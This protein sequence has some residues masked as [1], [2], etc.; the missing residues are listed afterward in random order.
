[1][2]EKKEILFLL[3]ILLLIIIFL[4]YN[5]IFSIYEITYDVSSKEMYADNQSTVKISVNSINGLGFKTPFRKSKTLFTIIEG[6]DLVEIIKNDY[7]NGILIVKAKYL[8]GKVVI[9]L[10][11]VYSLFPSVVEIQIVPNTV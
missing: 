4:A 5:Y 10:K 6:K 3:I 7:A 8:T 1:M 11:S 2:M 9:K